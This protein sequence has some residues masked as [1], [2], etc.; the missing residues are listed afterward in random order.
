MDVTIQPRALTGTVSAVPSKSEAHR[1]LILAAFAQGPS[2]ISCPSTSADIEATASCLRALGAQ[3]E[4]DGECF[5]I[6]PLPRGN[7]GLPVARLGQ[8][9]DCGESG[10]TLR[11]LLPIVAAVDCDAR[12]SGKGRLFER[13]LSPLYEQLVEHGAALSP[14]GVAP[15]AVSG[16]IRGGV[17]SLPGNVS[18]QFVSGLLMAAGVTDLGIEVRVGE[19]VQ[20]RP[21]IE[22]T[23]RMLKRFGIGVETWPRQ[24]RHGNEMVW[25]V[26]PEQVPGSPGHVDIAG[27]WSNAAFWLCAGAISGNGVTV[28]GLDLASVQ[29]D[30][31]IMAILARMGARVI[32][33]RGSV[34]VMPDRLVTC[35][36]DVSD[37]PDLVPPLALVAA[38]AKGTSRIHGA[39]RLRLKESDRIATVA[40]ALRALGVS[41]DEHE[42]GL[43][44]HGRGMLAGGSV[45]AAND[46][47]IAMMAAI[48]SART[49]GPVVI[50]GAECVA[51]SYPAF[52]D[53]FAFLGGGLEGRDD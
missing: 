40:S 8:V 53:D 48:A 21:Y 23:S 32:R 34:T 13:P 33:G 47:R 30:R 2:T 49:E 35:E 3:V 44:I 1:A 41:V 38:C 51:K 29:G 7:K 25:S 5:R 14:Q 12:L 27:D 52:F 46:H 22:I 17:F 42:D 28:T 19:P 9:L 4:H 36:I 15:L 26:G 45:D 24:S 18:S 50:H 31:A 6:T 10:S 11:F 39:A 43:D 16:K 20:S 37:I